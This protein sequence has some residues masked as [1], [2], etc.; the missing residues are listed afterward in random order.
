MNRPELN[1]QQ[2]SVVSTRG[3]ELFVSA[4]A[5]SGKTRVLAERFAAMVLAGE[6]PGSSAALDRILLITYTDKAAAE[7]SQRVRRVF[8]EH[9]RPDLARRV[10][11]AWI[12]TIHGF[13]ARIVRRHALDLG[14]DPGFAVL[15]DPD[16]GVVRS[17]A[18]DAAVRRA[19]DGERV[20]ELVAAYSL[21]AV[22]NAAMS[23]YDQVRAM[24]ATQRTFGF[25]RSRI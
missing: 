7:L 18:F 13:C 21:E 11:E 25:H 17:A 6:E 15:A 22:R 19:M 10:D 4:G 14:I 20:A 16:V 12:S 8:L 2:S 23:A 3:G 9:R 1:V 24:D 5:G